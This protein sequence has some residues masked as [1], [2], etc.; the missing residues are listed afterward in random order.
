MTK[1]HENLNASLVGKDETDDG[2]SGS[3]N[4][5]K[6]KSMSM[7]QKKGIMTSYKG[8]NDQLRSKIAEIMISIEE[9]VN[10]K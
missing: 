10:T 7:V 4:F 3:L 1:K 2:F 6:N 8:M 5:R 9:I